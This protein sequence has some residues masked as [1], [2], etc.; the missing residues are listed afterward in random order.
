MYLCVIQISFFASQKANMSA[1]ALART[2]HRL[3]Y[4]HYTVN[5]ET[6]GFTFLLKKIPGIEKVTTLAELINIPN[7]H[8]G[9]KVDGFVE[10]FFKDSIQ[11]TAEANI[12]RKIKVGGTM[13]SKGN[14]KRSKPL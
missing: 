7:M 6:D 11:G 13:L 4:L 10:K 12:W 9:M 1:V 8:F 2:K 14:V 3:Q 5:P